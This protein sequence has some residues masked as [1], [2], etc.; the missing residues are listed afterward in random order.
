MYSPSEFKIP[1][2]QTEAEFLVEFQTSTGK[3]NLTTGCRNIEKFKLGDTVPVAYNPKNKEAM[4]N[5]GW[6]DRWA[7]TIRL[8][9]IGFLAALG[10]VLIIKY[11]DRL[12]SFLASTRSNKLD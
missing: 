12:D 5:I 7:D 3:S 11:V 9:E 10:S 4:L 8:F 6:M 1:C 2:S